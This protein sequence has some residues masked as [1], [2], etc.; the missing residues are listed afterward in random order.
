M[1]PECHELDPIDKLL[2]TS[3]LRLNMRSSHTSGPEQQ[4]SR[5]V[6]HLHL[7]IRLLS[8]IS[9]EMGQIFKLTHFLEGNQH[10]HLNDT[11]IDLNSD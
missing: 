3:Q 8:D 7:I 5:L 10:Q 4:P 1:V 9:L 6:S 2:I 11:E